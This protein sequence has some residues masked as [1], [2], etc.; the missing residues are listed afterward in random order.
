MNEHHINHKK[1]AEPEDMEQRLS[2]YYGPPLPEQP[3]PPA[4]W[5]TVRHR[6]G[7]QASARCRRGFH[8]RLPRKRA[9]AFV[10]TMIQDAFARIASE[11]GGA[12]LVAGQANY[13]VHP[14]AGHSDKHRAG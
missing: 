10:P 1:Q 3:L 8:L 11:A 4:S 7:V 14:A 2:A 12:R 6:L 9:R 13:P 5:H